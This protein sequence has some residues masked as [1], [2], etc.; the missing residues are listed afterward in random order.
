MKAVEKTTKVTK[1][2]GLKA[3]YVLVARGAYKYHIFH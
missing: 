3:K 1:E 2:E